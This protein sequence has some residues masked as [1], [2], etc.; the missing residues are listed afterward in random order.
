MEDRKSLGR[1]GLVSESYAGVDV[2]RRVM[3]VLVILGVLIS[4]TGLCMMSY[5]WSYPDGGLKTL[6]HKVPFWLIIG[7]SLVAIVSGLFSQ[8][9]AWWKRYQRANAVQGKVR[10]DSS[11]GTS[12]DAEEGRSLIGNV[13]SSAVWTTSA[14]RNSTA[15]FSS[16]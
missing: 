1:R 2:F 8:L 11:M 4:S 13:D 5:M 10:V 14:G 7:G 16:A 9:A 12:Y 3:K 15:N 6:S